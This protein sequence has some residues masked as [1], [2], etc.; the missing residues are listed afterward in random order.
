MDTQSA[1]QSGGVPVWRWPAN[2]RERAARKIDR[3]RRAAR[4]MATPRL[5]TVMLVE[6]DAIPMPEWARR[7]AIQGLTLTESSVW[8]GRI[9]GRILERE[10]QRAGG[11]PRVTVERYRPCRVCKRPLL[12]LDA[13][14]RLELDRKWNGERIPCGPECAEIQAARLKRRGR[15]A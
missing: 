3:E 4:G 14:R 15:A 8:L 10:D 9:A 12:G 6:L 11:S 13:E 7:K 2:R 5:R 1:G